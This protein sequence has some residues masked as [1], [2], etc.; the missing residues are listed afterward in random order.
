MMNST[1]RQIVLKLNEHDA[2]QLLALI[3]KELNQGDKAWRPYWTRLTHRVEQSIERA[4]FRFFQR[5][6]R[7]EDRLER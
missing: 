6:L 1:D 5:A 3:Q 4:S 7:S 2:S